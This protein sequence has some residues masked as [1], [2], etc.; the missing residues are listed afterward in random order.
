MIRGA[1]IVLNEIADT[2]SPMDP[3]RMLE[4]LYDAHARGV[5]AWCRGMLGHRDDADDAVQAVWLKLARRPEKLGEVSDLGAYLWATTRHHVYSLLRRRSLERWWTPPREEEDEP[6]LSTDSEVSPE[7]R[8]DLLRAVRG[9][10]P[11]FRGVVLLVAFEG[12]T[13]E[14]TAVRLGIPRGTAASRYHTAISKLQQK[15]GA[16]R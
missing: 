13:L 16:S 10:A 3:S 15:I 2:L 4:D 14:E 7:E 5:H 6:P 8:R 9:L 12:C 11:R 1:A